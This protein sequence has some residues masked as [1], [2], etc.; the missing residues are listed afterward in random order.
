VLVDDN[1]RYPVSDFGQSERD[2]R[3]IVSLGHLISGSNSY[4]PYILLPLRER[5][6][7]SDPEYSEQVTDSTLSGF[8]VGIDNISDLKSQPRP[9]CGF[10]DIDTVLEFV[11]GVHYRCEV[12]SLTSSRGKRGDGPLKL[13]AYTKIN[14]LWRLCK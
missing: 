3:H 1:R 4:F 14:C 2:Q 8:S 10:Q 11:S 9:C 12:R 7:Q 13:C 5:Q 6:K